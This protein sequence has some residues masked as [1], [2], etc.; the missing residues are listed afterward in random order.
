LRKCY[1]IEKLPGFLIKYVG[2]E[3]IYDLMWNIGHKLNGIP[4]KNSQHFHY[5]KVFGPFATKEAL[6]RRELIFQV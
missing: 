2:K 1:A 4:C 6:D 5:F 3:G